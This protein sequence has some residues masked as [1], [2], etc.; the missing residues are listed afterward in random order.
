VLQVHPAIGQPWS[1]TSG[2]MR[3]LG[4]GINC[5]FGRV[6]LAQLAK[7]VPVV[8]LFHGSKN[9]E[10]HAAAYAA[11]YRGLGA[12]V[13][14]TTADYVVSMGARYAPAILVDSGKSGAVRV[15]GDPL[16]VVHS[17]TDPENCHTDQ[18]LAIAGELGIAVDYLTGKPHPVVMDAKAR[19]HAGFD[20]L[21]GAFSVNTL[22]NARLGIVPLVKVSHE[23]VTALRVQ[24]FEPPDIP[25][26]QNIGD[27][28]VALRAIAMDADL[29]GHWQ[30]RARLW[31]EIHRDPTSLA[32]R[33][34]AMY[35][36][37]I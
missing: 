17:P 8:A 10:R 21:R 36:E 15:T 19:A 3:T 7:R 2:R 11:H 31:T 14:A 34:A 5:L 29:C 4:D 28:R 35:Q 25:P 27:L 9:A 23:C 13:W 20:H 18:F 26:I 16:V 22:E 37:V 12:H 1:Y 32:H 33:L 30:R 24:G 6:H